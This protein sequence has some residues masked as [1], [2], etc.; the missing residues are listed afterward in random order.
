MSTKTTTHHVHHLISPV[1]D[2]GGEGEGLAWEGM[3]V[4][5]MKRKR[6]LMV[7]RK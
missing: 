7:E 4:R 6:D 3:F 1:T 5:P 2:A